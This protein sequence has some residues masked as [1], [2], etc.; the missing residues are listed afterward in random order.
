MQCTDIRFCVNFIVCPGVAHRMETLA[1][2]VSCGSSFR[3]DIYLDTYSLDSLRKFKTTNSFHLS[4]TSRYFEDNPSSPT[5]STF[6]GPCS[7]FML[8]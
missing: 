6:V 3:Y 8:A 4:S 2:S 1:T 5:W 7:F